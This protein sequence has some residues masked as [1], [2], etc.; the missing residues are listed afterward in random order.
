LD[1]VAS[2]SRDA[3][4]TL[5]MV[6]N[7]DVVQTRRMPYNLERRQSPRKRFQHLLYVELE[8]AN[9]G[10]VLNFSEHGFGFRAVKRV[11][12]NQEVKFAFNLDD[13]RRLEGRGRLE[14]A[15]KDGR[16]AGLQFTDVSE[17]FYSE[18]RSWLATSQEYAGKPAGK[19]GAAPVQHSLG[20]ASAAESAEAAVFSRRRD[21]LAKSASAKS[22]RPINSVPSNNPAHVAESFAAETPNSGDAAHL[23]WAAT[24]PP[25]VGFERRPVV[26][27]EHSQVPIGASAAAAAFKHAMFD[28][29]AFNAEPAEVPETEES[30]SAERQEKA[31]LPD[32][33][34]ADPANA[35]EHPAAEVEARTAGSLNEHAQALL[36]HFKHEEERQLAVFRESAARVLRDADRQLFPIRESVQA[37]FKSLESSV[38]AADASAKV[39]DQYP[40]LL[41]R[42]QQQALDRFQAQVQ[43]VLRVH[44]TELRRRSEGVLEEINTRVRSTAL[45]PQ[46]IRT[47][48]GIVVSALIL[49]LLAMLFAFR[50]EAAGAFIWLGDQMVDQTSTTAPATSGPAIPNQAGGPTTGSPAASGTSAS[51]TKATDAK[52]KDQPLPAP[53]SALAAPSEAA[54]SPKDVR[55][56]WNA[57]GKGDVSAELTLGTMYFTGHGVTKNCSQARRLFAAAARKGNEEGKQKLA[58]LDGGACS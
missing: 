27:P 16:V 29:Q 20:D 3:S 23:P 25:A 51:D 33:R 42:A 54:T 55:S 57:V 40:A 46:R 18:M 58:L 12:P 24:L 37:Q 41:E 28:P 21:S 35:N 7:H 19:F 45:L 9:G 56:L 13:K 6:S 48:S 10:M 30:E 34:S 14:W 8:P 47:S 36:Q 32:A 22:V 1:P 5:Q 26:V 2:G 31:A 52:P 4:G 15:D 50:R 38:A 39:L 53:T 49:V 44:I 11:R 17:E 43:E